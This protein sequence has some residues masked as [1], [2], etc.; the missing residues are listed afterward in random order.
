MRS[1]GWD[2]APQLLGAVHPATGVTQPGAGAAAQTAAAASGD[3]V[4]G[5]G[6]GMPGRAEGRVY[7]VQEGD[8]LWRIAERELGDGHRWR[9]IFAANHGRRMRDGQLLA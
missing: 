3:V 1:A 7:V 4:R 5:R 9:E 8:S 2:R 6:S